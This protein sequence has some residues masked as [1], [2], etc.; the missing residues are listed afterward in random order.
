MRKTV[1]IVDDDSAVRDSLGRVLTGSGYEVVL[2]ADG[3]AALDWVESKPIDI[4]L[5]DLGLPRLRGWE[6]FE[7]IT[8]RNPLLPIIIITG[9]E[10]QEE[11]AVAAG[12]GALMKK[13]VDV[14]RLLT[15]IRDLLREP[16]RARL[17]RLC[18]YTAD[19]RLIPSDGKAFLK[20]V[21][22]RHSGSEKRAAPVASEERRKHP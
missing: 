22:E 14:P 5:L 12:V 16:R 15:T 17:L 11:M 10:E 8:R 4:L 1:L 3:L 18:G 20:E 19:V 7:R 21:R 13:P 2:A 6:A 9:Q